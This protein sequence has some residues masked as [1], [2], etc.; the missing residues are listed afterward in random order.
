MKIL[1]S[2]ILGLMGYKGRVHLSFSRPLDNV[3]D[4]EQLA[5]RL[6]KDIVSNY[7]T[8]PYS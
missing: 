8:F 6:D 7:R 1:Q 5:E 4:V 2:M 3:G